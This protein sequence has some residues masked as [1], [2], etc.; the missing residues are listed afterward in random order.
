MRKKKVT[1]N[2]TIEEKKCDN[3]GPKNVIKNRKEVHP[4]KEQQKS[5]KSYS[6]RSDKKVL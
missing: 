2:P 4:K 3:K 5:E 1:K 6:E